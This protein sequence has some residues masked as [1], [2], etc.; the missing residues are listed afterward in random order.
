MSTHAVVWI[1]RKEARI[2]HVRPD[3][4]QPESV[5]SPQH[6]LHRHPKGHTAVHKHPDDE[7]HFF[8]GVAQALHGT[9]A[10]L[11]V[12]PASAKLELLRYLQQREHSLAAAVVGVE[13]ADHPTDGQIVAH[14]RH[15]FKASDALGLPAERQA[16]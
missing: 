6:Q 11:I 7:K 15:Y 2:F 10:I 3:A 16:I 12:G 13:S 14:A 1:D 9:G 5:L 4:V 8:A